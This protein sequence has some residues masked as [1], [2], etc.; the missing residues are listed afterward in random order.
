MKKLLILFISLFA[1]PFALLA[2]PA[3]TSDIAP[4]VEERD[5]LF[6]LG[7]LSY[8]YH[9]LE[10]E[11]KPGW[12]IAAL[13][14]W[15]V[16][17]INRT[18]D[19][20]IERNQNFEKQGNIFHAEIMAIEKA[21]QKNKSL[22]VSSSLTREEINKRLGMTTTTLYTSLEPCPLCKMGATW[23]RI[24]KV[25]YFMDDPGIRNIETYAP[26]S[27]PQK[28]CGRMLIQVN[29]SSLPLALKINQELRDLFSQESPE[30][31]VITLPSGEKILNFAK[32]FEE[33]LEELLRCGHELF[34]S[35]EILYDQNKDLY[36]KLV[37]ATELC[38]DDK[39]Y[40]SSKTP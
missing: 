33:H 6:T 39:S 25:V 35:Y 16:E 3:F 30:G 12:H 23:S 18:P 15:D 28:F 38:P 21:S 7:V 37:N 36:A 5:N 20:V 19:F 29:P 26:V 14:A 27:L 11:P 2:Q 22:S 32:Y 17:D 31:Y 4:I 34:C 13:I 10:T 1:T 9:R 24:P 8:L 40:S